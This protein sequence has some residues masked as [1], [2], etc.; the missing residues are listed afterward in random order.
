MLRNADAV[1]L[2]ARAPANISHHEN[3]DVLIFR[4]LCGRV[5]RGDEIAG[6]L[7][8]V[9]GEGD[10]VSEENDKQATSDGG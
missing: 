9:D 8:Q 2:H 4:L 6:L 10:E 5:A 7:G 1:V 3:L